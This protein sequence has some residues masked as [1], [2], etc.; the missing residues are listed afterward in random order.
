MNSILPVSIA[1]VSNQLRSSVVTSQISS[2]QTQLENIQ[3]E[4][5]TGKQLNV[6]S[7]NPTDSAI[8]Q[9]IQKTIEKRQA[10]S[11]TLSY[12]KSSLGQTDTTLGNLSDLLDQAKT[13]ASANVGS[14]VSDDSRKAASSVASSIYSQLLSLSNTQLNGVYIFSGDST[15]QAF[16][17]Q[18]GD[19]VATG[20]NGIISNNVDTTSLTGLTVSTQS[21]FNSQTGAA[22][23]ALNVSMTNNTRLADIGGGISTGFQPGSI[24][25]S[26]G[27]TSK[28]VDLTACKSIGDVVTKINNAAVGSITASITAGGQAITLSGSATENIAVSDQPNGTTAASLGILNSGGAGANTPLVGANLDPKLTPLTDLSS[29]SGVDFASGLTI[30]N[31]ATTKTVNFSACTNV[32]DVLNTLNG[33]GLSLNATINASGTGINITNAS[34]TSTLSIAENGGTTAK[35]LGVLSFNG[36][37]TLASLNG[38]K[39]VHTVDGTDFTITDSAGVAASVDL[40]GAVTVNDAIA[41]INAAATSAGAGV[42]AA[43]TA[44]GRSISL[45]DTAAGAGTLTVAAANNSTTVTDLGLDTAASSGVITSRNVG[46]IGADSIFTHVKALQDA[47]QTSDQAAITAA[48]EKLSSDYDRVT[49]QRGINGANL[50]DVQSRA[51]RIDDQNVASKSWMSDLQDVDYTSAISQF[52]LLQTA[53]Q[54]T[55]QTAGK[56]L[57]MSL[58]DFLG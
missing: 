29:I 25:I 53:L 45:T 22:G 5:S 43:L 58:L 32:Q 36:N 46:G 16:T 35:D 54:A 40:D 26:D 4:L 8:V 30:T 44:D 38:G 41:K 6:P 39:G 11:D 1:R 2:T 49:T 10:Y 9:Q 42:T 17:A 55:M 57:N 24:T 28:L 13:L 18:G 20:G 3:N 19:I 23:S 50:Q 56:T 27:T 48:A 7:D 31:G 15:Q 37:T 34:Q 52:T 33:A 14:D 47:L 51:D 21:V 12:A